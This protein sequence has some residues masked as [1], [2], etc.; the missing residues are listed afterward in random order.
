M[1][2][3]TESDPKAYLRYIRYPK[4]AILAVN[5]VRRRESEKETCITRNG[6]GYTR[7]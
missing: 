1:L 6:S 3:R 4:G 2:S 5:Y 7:A